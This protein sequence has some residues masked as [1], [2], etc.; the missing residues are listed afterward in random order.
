VRGA[1]PAGN[2]E[3]PPTIPRFEGCLPASGFRRV[4]PRGAQPGGGD[5]EGRSHTMHR[6]SDNTRPGRRSRGAARGGSFQTDLK[7]GATRAHFEASPPCSGRDHVFRPKNSR[8]SVRGRARNQTPMRASGRTRHRMNRSFVRKGGACLPGRS[9]VSSYA[10][11]PRRGC[12]VPLRFVSPGARGR[13]NTNPPAPT[14][15]ARL[16]FGVA[17]SAVVPAPGDA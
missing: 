4:D 10:A 16:T 2:C 6:V 11:H 3:P 12:C 14:T 15:Y 1:K 5:M 8:A 7:G 13:L 9:C 17:R